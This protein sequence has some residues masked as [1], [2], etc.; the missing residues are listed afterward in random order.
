MENEITIVCSVLL[1][2]LIQPMRPK[3]KWAIYSEA[4]RARGIF[5]LVKSDYFVKNVENEK[6][7]AS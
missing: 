7:L 1:T 6:L 2:L 3:A 5:V 4:M